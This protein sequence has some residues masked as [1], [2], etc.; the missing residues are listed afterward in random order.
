MKRVSLIVINKD[1]ILFMKYVLEYFILELNSL[2][3]CPSIKASK[4]E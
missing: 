4:Q 1:G 2:R 3:G